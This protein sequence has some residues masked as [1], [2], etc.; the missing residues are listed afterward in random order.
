[1]KTLNITRGNLFWTDLCSYWRVFWMSNLNF[2]SCNCSIHMGVENFVL[3]SKQPFS[4]FVFLTIFPFIFWVP[5]LLAFSY[6][7][8]RPLTISVA[9][10]W[11]VSSSGFFLKCDAD[12]GH[13]CPAVEEHDSIT[14]GCDLIL[15]PQDEV[16]SYQHS[17]NSIALLGH[18]ELQYNMYIFSITYIYS[19]YTHIQYNHRPFS[20][21]VLP[22]HC[23]FSRFCEIYYAWLSVA[24]STILGKLHPI[25]SI[26][27]SNL[28]RWIFQVL[29]LLVSSFH[30]LKI[31]LSSQLKIIPSFQC[32]GLDP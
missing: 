14:S 24:R 20:A 21:E 16:F 32:T 30:V 28:I 7:F 29:K 19:V 15:T 25:F 13:C 2:S 1:M 23:S 18:T 4:Y 17:T 3:P 5:I 27:F 8:P 22:D 9:L 12:T 11:A 6:R 10:P 26:H 31:L